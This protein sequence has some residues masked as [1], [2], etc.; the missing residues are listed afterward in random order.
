[1]RLR[2]EAQKLNVMRQDLTG[3]IQGLSQDIARL[4][5]ENKQLNSMRS[6]VDGIRKELAARRALEY[7]KK[8]NEEQVEQKEVM[9]KNLMSMAREIEKLRAE[10]VSMDRR[11]HGL[12]GTVGSGYGSGAGGIGYGSSAGGSGYGSALAAAMW[13]TSADGYGGAWGPYNKRTRR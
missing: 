5:S 7:E 6:D 2:A 13:G 8:A 11:G 10:H 9:E 1:M 3:Q 4:R 12:G